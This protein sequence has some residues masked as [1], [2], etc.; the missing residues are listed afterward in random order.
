MMRVTGAKRFQSKL[1][2]WIAQGGMEAVQKATEEAAQRV[3]QG[4]QQLAPVGKTRAVKNSIGYGFTKGEPN[5]VNAKI[6]VN[7]GPRS[8]RSGAQ[9]GMN[10]PHAHLVALGTKSRFTKSGARRGRMPANPFV[11]AGFQATADGAARVAHWVMLREMR[12]QLE[13]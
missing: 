8:R 7:A 4:I 1:D 11:T 2:R 6:G 5:Q 3:Q 12:S 13:S 10:E 9:V